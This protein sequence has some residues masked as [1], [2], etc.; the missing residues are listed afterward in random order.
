MLVEKNVALR[1]NSYLVCVLHTDTIIYPKHFN[2]FLL[3]EPFESYKVLT[4]ASK[5]RLLS[6]AK[7]HVRGQP[8]G[9]IGLINRYPFL[10]YKGIDD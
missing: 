4:S 8:Y 7:M 2:C 1:G 5:Y 6:G 9:F 3:S 10:L